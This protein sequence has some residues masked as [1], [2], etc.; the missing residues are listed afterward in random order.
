VEA[1]LRSYGFWL[2][3]SARVPQV[4]HDSGL[5]GFSRHYL[6]VDDLPIM[7]SYPITSLMLFM[8]LYIVW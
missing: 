4:Y 3:V 1:M 8:H 6:K 2:R 7:V 5:S